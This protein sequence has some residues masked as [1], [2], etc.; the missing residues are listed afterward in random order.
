M[1]NF[2]FGLGNFGAN[3]DLYGGTPEKIYLV[4]RI[5]RRYL[6]SSSIANIVNLDSEITQSVD[7]ESNY[8]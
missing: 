5:K 8:L 1:G 6:F 2:L 4:S 7:F 3:I